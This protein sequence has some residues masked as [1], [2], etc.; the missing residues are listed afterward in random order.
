[1]SDWCGTEQA[2]KQ[3]DEATLDLP[4]VLAMKTEDHVKDDPEVRSDPD[5]KDHPEVTDDLGVTGS[6]EANGSMFRSMLTGDAEV[7]QGTALLDNIKESVDHRGARVTRSQCG[8]TEHNSP[9]HRA[10][11]V[12]LYLFINL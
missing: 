6:P 9:A 12:S 5:I 1:M 2:I 4:E 3:E 10:P 8:V 7:I 11:Y